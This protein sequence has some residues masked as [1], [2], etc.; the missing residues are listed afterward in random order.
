MA[1]AT[2]YVKSGASIIPLELGTGGGSGG[3]STSIE[4]ETHTVETTPTTAQ[5]YAI[6][7][8]AAVLVFVNS[9]FGVEGVT[10]GITSG[11]TL[12]FA[13]I[14]PEGTEI[15]IVKFKTAGTVNPTPSFSIDSALSDTSTNAVQNKIVKAGIDDTFEKAVKA[16]V[17]LAHPVGSYYW[18]ENPTNP[19]EL[20]G[21]TWETIENRFVF[22]AGN[23]TVGS[24]G[25]EESHTLTSSEMPSHTHNMKFVLFNGA[26]GSG[27]KYGSAWN[28]GSWG[29]ANSQNADQVTMYNENA[30]GGQAHNNMPPYV[31]AYC[32]KRTA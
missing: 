16:A 25:G 32:W 14:L 24:T 30:G 18:S 2:L 9:V 29:I 12:Q 28:N 26:S 11:T 23:K 17:L 19:S 20:F 21:G 6:G 31:V 5:S 13:D 15:V 1:T 22:A 3:G 4:V 7:T 10:Y 27:I 8:C